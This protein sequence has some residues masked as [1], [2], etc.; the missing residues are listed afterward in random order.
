[1]DKRILAELEATGLPWEVETG[2]KHDKLRLDGK[3]VGI[4]SRSGSAQ[5]R[6]IKNTI[7]NIRRV[8]RGL[9]NGRV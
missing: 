7:S 5:P 1:M 4:V 6:S 2:G 9:P 8:S 3:L